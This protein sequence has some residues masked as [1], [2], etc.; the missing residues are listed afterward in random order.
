MMDFLQM[1][2]GA[3]GVLGRHLG[4]TLVAMLDRFFQLTHAF[5]KMRIFDFFLSH[6]GMVQCFLC[7]GDNGIGMPHAAMFCR[8][9]R[10][11]NRF[12]N[13]LIL[14]GE[15]GRSHQYEHRRHQQSGEKKLLRHSIPPC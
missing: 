13:V 15:P 10:V 2:N 14:I 7:M 3:F 4:M 6:S 8:F 12:R 9:F 1:H 5:I 11:R